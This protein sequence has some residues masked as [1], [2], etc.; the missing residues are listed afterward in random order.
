MQYRPLGRT[1]IDVSVICLGT[2]TFGEQNSEAEAHAQ[3][4]FAIAHGVNFIDTAEI[5]PSPIKAETQGA[6]ERFIGT[7]LRSRKDR[8]QI[9]LASKVAGPGDNF[10][11][12]RGGPR[13]NA[14][15]INRAVEA[16][17]DRLQTDYLDL[18]QVHWPARPSNFFGKL[19]YAHTDAAEGEQIEETLDAL[20]TL[21]RAGK[22]RTV[23]LSNESPWG[24]M[25][26]LRHAE[27]ADK[28]RIVSV[29]NPYCLLN[30]AFEV[31]LAEMAHREDV[32]LLA[33]SPLGFGVLSGKYLDGAR[34]GNARISRW[35][36]YYPRYMNDHAQ[37]ATRRYVQI[38]RDAGLDPAQ[39][40][41][42]FVNTRGFVTANIIGATTQSQLADNIAS[43]DVTLSD[44]VIQAIEE[45]HLT[46]SNPSP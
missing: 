24:V 33:Y 30:R 37:A 22:V 40:A 17:L 15:H 7:W 32:G 38:A 34:P 8:D 23:G 35:E 4:D 11:Y 13:L 5:Y 43:I 2:M 39:M 9:I 20:D 31:G 36:E 16:S 10:P 12:I 25:R 1:G 21:V 42:A 44:D 45:V 27:L 41:L 46:Y 6:T 19:G 29:Q 28:T 14:D 26:Y 3:L 18:Y